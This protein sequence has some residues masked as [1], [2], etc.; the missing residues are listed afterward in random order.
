MSS[1]LIM[2]TGD[3]INEKIRAG[4]AKAAQKLGQDFSLYRSA[5]P[6]NPIQ[7][8]YLVGIVKAVMTVSWNW[9]KPNKYGNAVWNAVIDGQ[10]SS[11][12]LSAQVGDYIVGDQTFFIASKQY[13]MPMQA[14]ECNRTISIERPSQ[15]TGAGYQGYTASTPAS[16]EIV[17]TR[18]PVSCLKAGDNENAPTRLPTDTKQ[19]MWIILMPNL[20]GVM[21]RSDDTIIDDKNQQYVVMTPELTDLGWRMTA[22]QTVNSR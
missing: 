3:L 10:L 19:P 22:Q 4:Y 17:M 5:T 6:I 7:S 1:G 15:H 8:D 12:N 20:G 9:M 21:I 11:G 2:G 18:M 14:V 16:S 13:Q